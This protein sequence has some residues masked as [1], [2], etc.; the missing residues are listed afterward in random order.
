[1]GFGCMKKFIFIFVIAIITLV[2]IYG[3]LWLASAKKYPVE[4]GISFNQIHASSLGLDWKEAYGAVLGELKPKYVR[5]AAMWSQVEPENG[6]FVWDEVD[7]MM[8]EAAENGVKILLVVGQKAPRWPECHVPAWVDYGNGEARRELLEYVERA[9][10]RYKNHPALELWQVE[11]EPFIRF[12]FGECAQYDADAAHDEIALIRSLD[13][14]HNIVVTDS[15]ELSTWRKASGSGDILGTTM[16]R[17]VRNK[18]GRVIRHWWFPPALYTL[19]ARFWGIPRD[20]FFVSEL[21]A[22]PWFTA[23]N[24]LNTPIDVQEQTMN[25]DQLRDNIAYAKKISASRAYFWGVEW[26][27][28]MKTRNDDAR[29]WEIARETMQDGR[30]EI[31]D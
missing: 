20:R 1:M 24:P 18:K 28:W 2:A 13:P 15:G 22:E 31:S 14:D 21:Q 10:E 26:W 19:K 25:S 29:Y 8:D 12:R 23:S 7:F 9:V 30:L 11:N 3:L 5:I 17:T 16:Y 4:F 6:R 27:Y